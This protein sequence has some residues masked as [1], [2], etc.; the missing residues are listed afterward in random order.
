MVLSIQKFTAWYEEAGTLI[1]AS[2]I[3]AGPF[4]VLWG[5]PKVTANGREF[6]VR[7]VCE[8]CSEKIYI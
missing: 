1:G 7:K 6:W 5:Y 8:I 3:L 2:V 4:G